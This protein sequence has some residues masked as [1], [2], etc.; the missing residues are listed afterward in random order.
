VLTLT[1]IVLT[2]ALAAASESL[3]GYRPVPAGWHAPRPWLYQAWCLHDGMLRTSSGRI[4]YRVGSGEGAW[5]AAT[6]N[7]YEG[8]L[9]FLRSTWERAGGR[10]S[11]SGHWA[12]VATPREQLYRAYVIWLSHGGSWSEWGSMRVACGLR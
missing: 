1:L 6:G 5:N 10:T 4:L 2:F 3:A 7:G 9:Q 8:G 12:S 11:S